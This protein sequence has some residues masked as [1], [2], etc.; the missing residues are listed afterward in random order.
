MEHVEAELCDNRRA[1]SR[2]SQFGQAA[3]ARSMPRHPTGAEVLVVQDAVKAAKSRRL[4]C[5]E[6]AEFALYGALRRRLAI[7]RQ[8]KLEE[9]RG[10]KC[11]LAGT[12]NIWDRAR[13]R[14][15]THT[16]QS[17]GAQSLQR[18]AAAGAAVSHPSALFTCPG[19][20]S[21]RCHS[22]KGGT[23]HVPERLVGCDCAARSKGAQFG[24][25]QR[26]D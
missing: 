25:A 22:L 10:R 7:E 23:G 13:L 11:P 15:D 18:R 20:W 26:Q 16:D 5:E 6:S 1:R 12:R 17:T 19:G 24:G 21:G 2:S 4:T 14:A 8:A 3:S 9:R